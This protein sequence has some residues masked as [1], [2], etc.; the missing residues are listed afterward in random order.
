METINNSP[1]YITRHDEEKLRKLIDEG[2]HERL[3]ESELASLVDR[4][5]HATIVDSHK[6]PRNIVTMNSLVAIINLDTSER[7]TFSLVFP[8]DVSPESNKISVLEPNRFQL[9]GRQVGDEFEWPTPG[10]MQAF[11]IAKIVYQPEAWEYR[12]H[13]PSTGP[14]W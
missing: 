9:L 13:N 3:S 11:V 6:I 10:G 14:R 12:K 1:S 4:I 5:N 8:E 2:K 7:E